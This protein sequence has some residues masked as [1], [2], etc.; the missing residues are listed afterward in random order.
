MTIQIPHHVSEDLMEDTLNVDLLRQTE[1][2][3]ILHVSF[4][5]MEQRELRQEFLKYLKV[6]CGWFVVS[7]Y[8]C[9]ILFCL[10]QEFLKYMRVSFGCWWLANAV[11]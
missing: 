4:A 8:C 7:K 6:S 10:G 9:R 1:G 3:T 11:A 5:V 2:T